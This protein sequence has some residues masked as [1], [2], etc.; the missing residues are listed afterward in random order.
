MVAANVRW[1]R[2]DETLFWIFGREAEDCA[3]SL[4]STETPL[5]PHE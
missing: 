5:Q 3:E 2:V 4:S 1:E